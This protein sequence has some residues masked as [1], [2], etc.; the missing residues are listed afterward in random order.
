MQESHASRAGDALSTVWTRFRSGLA[1]RQP[2]AQL[3]LVAIVST[4]LS[5][6]AHDLDPDTR[7]DACERIVTRIDAR[8]R[9]GT[10]H[11]ALELIDALDADLAH[12]LHGGACVP[13]GPTRKL[14]VR[15]GYALA[16]LP[17]AQQ[18][19][20]AASADLSTARREA[21]ADLRHRLDLA[22]PR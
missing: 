8:V 10:L 17:D 4:L 6:A 1:R 22:P 7:A 5:H 3:R 11:S 19:A 13:P 15:L 16:S 12:V 14:L 2:H 18:A 21:L 20:I 9:S